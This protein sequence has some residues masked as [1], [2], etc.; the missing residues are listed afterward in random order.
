MTE[1][2]GRIPTE[3]LPEICR[4]FRDH[5]YSGELFVVDKELD[6]AIFLVPSEAL[7][8]IDKRPLEQALQ[9]CLHRKVWIVE[10]EP[11]WLAQARALG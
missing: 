5:A 10:T 9:T 2:A 11:I 1:P 6:E 8:L 3:T 4:L 7:P